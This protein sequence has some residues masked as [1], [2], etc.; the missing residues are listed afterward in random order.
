MKEPIIHGDKNV[1]VTLRNFNYVYYIVYLF[2]I[3][4][5]A[6]SRL[7]RNRRQSLNLVRKIGIKKNK[8]KTK[9][10]IEPNPKLYFCKCNILVGQISN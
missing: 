2:V 8:Q 1:I 6:E 9:Q 4:G 3:L 10:N 5:D 7:M